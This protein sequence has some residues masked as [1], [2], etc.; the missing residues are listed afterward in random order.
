ML[1]AIIDWSAADFPGVALGD[2]LRN[3]V[4]YKSTSP[5]WGRSPASS[6]NVSEANTPASS[7][8]GSRSASIS[9]AERKTSSP[10]SP[11]KSLLSGGYFAF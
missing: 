6:P 7:Q 5:N 10:L 4:G 9:P 8:P 3:V 1:P 2:K 11:S